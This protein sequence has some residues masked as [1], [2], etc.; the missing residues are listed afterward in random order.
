MNNDVLGREEIVYKNFDA[1]WNESKKYNI[2]SRINMY[3]RDC[4][5]I[6]MLKNI[7]PEIIL[8]VGCGIGRTMSKFKKY[9]FEVV[10]IDNSKKSVSFCGKKGLKV[11]EMDASSMDFADNSF[12]V[13]FAEGLLEHFE[14]YNPLV[15]EMVRVSERYIILVQPNSHTFFGKILNVATELLTKGNVKELPYKMED[16][17]KSFKKLNCELISKKSA[18]LNTFAVF[19]FQ[20]I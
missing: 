10:G 20:K 15:K 18:A 14:N 13:V 3:L 9:G 2:I 6:D 4:V 12:D 5:V 7:S 11:S 8:D 19:L 17:I 16:Y 1:H